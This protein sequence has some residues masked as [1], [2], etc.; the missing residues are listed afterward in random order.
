MTM[1]AAANHK[2]Y[3][4]RNNY[5]LSSLCVAIILLYRPLNRVATEMAADGKF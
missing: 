1:G 2:H 5:D 4:G 3:H